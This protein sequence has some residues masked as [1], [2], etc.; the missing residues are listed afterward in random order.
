MPSILSKAAAT[1]IVV[2]LALATQI[3]VRAQGNT[4]DKVRYNG[5]TIATKTKPDDWDNRLTITSSQIT[6]ELEDGQRLVVDPERVTSI[7]Y[8][9]EA[10]RRVGT[11]IALGILV[12]PLALFGLFHKTKKHYIGVDYSTAD[13]KRAGMLLQGHKDNFRAILLSLSSVTGQ[14]VAVSPK[15]RDQVPANVSVTEVAQPSEKEQ[16][17][18]EEAAK[19]AAKQAPASTEPVATGGPSAPTAQPPA[20]T[21][22][23]GAVAAQP[24]TV[25][26]D[27]GDVVADIYVDD[28]FVGNTPSQLKL[29]PGRRAIRVIAKGYADW[30]RTIDVT[31]GSEVSL[32]AVLEAVP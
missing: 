30:T 25:R 26:L 14:P 16:K 11:M 15:D 29:A 21:G 12:A 28:A 13:G 22:T 19:A 8:G 9:Q 18:A 5:G 27:S 17:Q 3:P 1:A 31:S 7:S 20:D 2:I 10:H 6:L 24:G 32:K 23:A 4:W